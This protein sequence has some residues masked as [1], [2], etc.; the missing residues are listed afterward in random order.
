MELSSIL[1]RDKGRS[2]VNVR[3]A[4]RWRFTLTHFTHRTLSPL[5]HSRTNE[6]PHDE[7][8]HKLTHGLAELTHSRTHCLAQPTQLT[9]PSLTRSTR[10]LTPLCTRCLRN[11]LSRLSSSGLLFCLFFC[12]A[13]V[14]LFPSSFPLCACCAC[15]RL[16]VWLWLPLFRSSRVGCLT[17]HRHITAICL[18]CGAVCFVWAVVR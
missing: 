16:C 9:I 10:E 6:L 4:A 7:L 13:F 14:C 3:F 11:S 17:H 1:V 12:F 15:L 2:L 5:T 8:T 18:N